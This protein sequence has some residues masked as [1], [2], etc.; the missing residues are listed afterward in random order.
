VIGQAHP[1]SERDQRE[2]PLTTQLL[3]GRRPSAAADDDWVGVVVDRWPA[4]RSSAGQVLGP[5][6]GELALEHPCCLPH[7][8]Q[9]AIGSLM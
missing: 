6:L 2:P 3:D 8:D 9:I 7:L 5:L 4:M 1:R